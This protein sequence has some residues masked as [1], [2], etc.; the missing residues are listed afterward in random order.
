MVQECERQ[1]VSV[2]PRSEASG[3]DGVIALHHRHAARLREPP[4]GGRDGG[5]G[6]TRCTWPQATDQNHARSA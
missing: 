2:Q 6:R 3:A 1:A 4:G 5:P